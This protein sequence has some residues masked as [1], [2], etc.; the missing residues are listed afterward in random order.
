M[1]CYAWSVA[2]DAGTFGTELLHLNVHQ[3]QRLVPKTILLKN[4]ERILCNVVAE[5]GV[6]VNAACS[7]DHF[8]GMLQFVAGFG[9]RKALA[10]RQSLARTG[11]VIVSRRDLLAKYLIG[12]TVYNNAVA[13]LRIRAKDRLEGQNLHPLDDTRI[14]PDVY[15]RNAWATKI[16]MDAL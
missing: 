7:H 13:F 12:P 14:H 6:D 9:P 10:L 2:S 16:A 11:G 1:G 4:Y 5:V 15:H 8:H 3:L